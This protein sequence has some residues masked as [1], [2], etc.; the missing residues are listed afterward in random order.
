MAELEQT[1]SLIMQ[2][3]GVADSADLVDRHVPPVEVAVPAPA[4]L[5]TVA[6]D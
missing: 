4:G 2:R 6:A 1:Y 5:R 3:L